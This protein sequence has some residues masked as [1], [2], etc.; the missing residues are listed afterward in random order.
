[1]K[2]IFE[3]YKNLTDIEQK[4]A[5]APQPKGPLGDLEQYALLTAAYQVSLY[6]IALGE[7]VAKMLSLKIAVVD[8][9][10]LETPII[11]KDFF[12]PLASPV[13]TLLRVQ[14]EV[15]RVSTTSFDHLDLAQCRPVKAF[16]KDVKKFAPKVADVAIAADESLLKT[17]DKAVLAFIC[18][19]FASED[20]L[21]VQERVGILDCTRH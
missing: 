18:L 19:N 7:D 6:A 20:P 4:Q 17:I 21:T 12:K 10:F 14:R 3:T 9:S 2:L 16:K 1:M 5:A 15:V 13:I 11:G 8:K